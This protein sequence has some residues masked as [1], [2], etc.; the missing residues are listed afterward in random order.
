MSVTGWWHVQLRVA[1]NAL[2]CS[3]QRLRLSEEMMYND[4][5]D[6]E[7]NTL[8]LPDVANPPRNLASLQCV[9]QLQLTVYSWG[10]HV[11]PSG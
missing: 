1:P 2:P 6:S 11:L 8:M 7:G 10:A 5:V 3:L 4:V 9:Q